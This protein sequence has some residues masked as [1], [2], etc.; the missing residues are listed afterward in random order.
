MKRIFFFFKLLAVTFLISACTYNII[1]PSTPNVPIVDISFSTDLQPIFNANCVA[2]HTSQ[3]PVL[4]EGQSYNSLIDGGYV[5]VNDPEASIIYVK[6]SGGHPAGNALT[7]TEQAM[8]LKW[9]EEGA[10]NN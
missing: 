1:E 4:V 6:T 9:I 7:P 10:K 2:C 8:L 5:D 3:K